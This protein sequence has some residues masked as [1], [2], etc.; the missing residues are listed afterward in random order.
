MRSSNLFAA[1]AM[2]PVLVVYDN[3]SA[4]TILAHQESVVPATPG[5]LVKT[6]DDL[7]Q[8]ISALKALAPGWSGRGSGPIIEQSLNGAVQALQFAESVSPAGTHLALVPCPDGSV[9]IETHL[10]D[11]AF[12]MYFETDGSVSAWWL[13]KESGEEKE[14]DG[15][16]ATRL[17]GQWAVRPAAWRASAA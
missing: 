13:N 3:A 6:E 11:S 4:N 10:L 7:T 16:D 2:T 17:L 5:N 14:A 15:A 8:K 9:Q 1:M 12:E